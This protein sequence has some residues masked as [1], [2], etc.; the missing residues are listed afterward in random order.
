ML[1]FYLGESRELDQTVFLFSCNKSTGRIR[2]SNEGE[3]KWFTI[4]LIPYDE[5]WDDDRIWLPQ[6]LNG[7][8]LVGDFY[9]SE[10][11][12][13]VESHEIH[14]ATRINPR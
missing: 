4:E 7:D 8:G 6:L 13:K 12:E 14:P 1:N 3:L 2:R 10:N 5:M 9:F 11:C